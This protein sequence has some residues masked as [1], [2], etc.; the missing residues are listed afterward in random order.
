[1]KMLSQRGCVPLPK[2][3]KPLISGNSSLASYNDIFASTVVNPESQ[4]S[5]TYPPKPASAEIITKSKEEGANLCASEV[6]GEIIV[7]IPLDQLHPPEFHPFQVKHDATMERLVGNIGR[8]GVLTPGIVRPR[9]N[10]RTINQDIDIDNGGYELVSGNRRKMA[11]ELL[12][13]TTMPVIIRE[14][15]D[16]TAAI[17]MVDCNLEQRETLLPSEKAWAYKVKMDALN[18]RGIKNENCP[19]KH[20]WSKQARAEV[21]FS[22]CCA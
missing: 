5:P 10:N 6:S 13:L 16:S 15:S 8:Y 14:M 9:A 12:G 4:E 21:K 3:A 18:H 7:H 1:M 19:S 11:C 2:S 17:V 20:L 22:A